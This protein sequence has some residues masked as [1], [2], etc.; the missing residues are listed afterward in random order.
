MCAIFEQILLFGKLHFLAV[1]NF[2][3]VLD[4]FGQFT[5]FLVLLL[6]LVL[7]VTDTLLH[8]LNCLALLK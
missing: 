7:Q 5:I 4:L 1:N 8:I 6:Q 2:L 3:R